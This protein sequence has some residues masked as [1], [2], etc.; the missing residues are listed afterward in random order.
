MG[1]IE[2]PKIPKIP[3]DFKKVDGAM[4]AEVKTNLGILGEWE[5]GN[6]SIDAKTIEES[7]TEELDELVKAATEEIQYAF[8][9]FILKLAAVALVE[10]KEG[11]A[12]LVHYYERALEDLTAVPVKAL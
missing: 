8:T 12:P 6:L 7:S 1:S 2:W 4:V 11:Y 3:V 10:G 5:T 9:R